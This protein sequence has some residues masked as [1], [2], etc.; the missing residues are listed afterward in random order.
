MSLPRVQIVVIR[1]SEFIHSGTFLELAET[2]YEGLQSLGASVGMAENHFDSE[3][4]NIVLGW[5]LLEPKQEK[6]LPA[7]CILYNLEQ[8][9]NENLSMLKRLIQ[10]SEK[11]E[12]WDYSLRNINIL[13]E[14]GFP[15]SIHHV[16]IGTMP[17]LSRIPKLEVQD[18][19]VLFY[20]SGNP[21]RAK[22]LEDL[23]KTGL[24]VH[25]VFG[26][27]G[28][29]R[30]AL[31]ARSKVV[32]NLH[33]YETKIFEM[34]RVSYLW[35]NKKAVVSEL[36]PDTE[37]DPELEGAARFVPY[38]QIVTACQ[39]LVADH[40]ARK[41]LE[42]RAYETMSRREETQIL[43]QVLAGEMEI[44]CPPRVSSD[45]DLD[46]P[47][48]SII[49]PV[50]NK[51]DYTRQCI[52]KLYEGTPGNLF[53]LIVVDNASTDETP[54][55]LASLGERVKVITSAE[56]V[57]FVGACNLGAAK[58]K[59]KHLVFLN[60]DTVPLPGWLEALVK[61]VEND[62]L[63]GA[64]GSQLI[65]PDGR[66]QEAGGLIFQ[67]GSGWNF[68]RFMDP[69]DPA[70]GNPIEVDYCSGASLLVRRDVFER[71]GGFDTRYAPAYYEDTDLCFGVRSLGLKVMYCPAS[72]V[73]HFEGITAGTDLTAGFKRFQEINREKFVAKWAEMLALQDPPPARS[74]RTPTT[75]DRKRLVSLRKPSVQAALSTNS[76][77]IHILI[78]DPFMP[79]HDR[80]SGSLRLFRI[81]LL[82]R[83]LGCDV[84]YIARNG[85]GQEAYKKQ[86]ENVGV[87]VFSTDPEKMAQL[88]HRVNAQRIDLPRILAEH[89]CHIA[90][91]SFYDIAEQYLCDIRKV[92]P[93]TTIMVD[94]V[95]VHFLRETR[96][97]QLAKDAGAMKRAA[98]TRE[99]ELRVY[100]QA[101]LVVTVTEADAEVLREAGLTAATLVI[102]NIH[103]E[104]EITP[105]WDTRQGLVFVGNFNHTPNIDAAQW[106]CRKIMP[107]IRRLL[108]GVKLNI[109]GPNPPKEVLALA[110]S[111]IKVL[112]WVPETAPYLD[113][114]RVSVA[115]IRVGA[116]M[117]GKIGEALSRSL[118]VVTTTIGAEGMDLVSGVDAMVADHPEAFADAVASI[119]NNRGAWE[120][121]AL[122]GR[123][124]VQSRYGVK[125]VGNMLK[126]MLSRYITGPETVVGQTGGTANPDKLARLIAFHLPQFHPI[127]E[128]DHWWGRGFTE[129]TNV[130][131]AQPLFL[132][133][134]Q[135]Q[136]PGELGFYDLRLEE[137]R[138]A[139]AQLAREHGIEG[140]CFWHYWFDGKLLLERPLL[141]SLHAGTPDFPYCLAWANENWT[142]RW[143]GQET[144]VL[145]PQTYG[146]DS[147]DAAHFEW[148]L[149][150]MK[151]KRAITVNG[152]PIFLIYRPGDLPD[153][154]RT[155]SLWRSMASTAGLPGLYLIAIVTSFR[156]Q[157][158]DWIREGF[159]GELLFQPNFDELITQATIDK[160]LQ[161]VPVTANGATIATYEHVWPRLAKLSEKNLTCPDMFASVVPGWDNTARRAQA[162]TILTN[163][164]SN[165]FGAWLRLEVERVQS[166]EPD[167]KIVF[168]NAWNE[169]AEG[170]HLEPDTRSG[171]EYLEAARWA[172]TEP[173][174]LQNSITPAG[175]VGPEPPSNK[176]TWRSVEDLRNEIQDSIDSGNLDHALGTLVGFVRDVITFQ[177]GESANGTE[178]VFGCAELDHICAGIGRKVLNRMSVDQQKIW[179]PR[180]VYVASGLYSTGGHSRVLDDWTNADKSREHVIL[181]TDLFPGIDRAQTEKMYPNARFEWAPAASL[182]A[183]LNWLISTLHSLMPER[184]F[185]FNHPEDSVAVS[186]ALPEL[187]KKVYFVHHADHS[188]S[189]G[190]F[191]QDVTHIDVSNICY[192]ICKTEH[193][194]KNLYVP[195]T[196]ID[197]GINRTPLRD[198][199]GAIVTCCSSSTFNKLQHHSYKYNYLDL[200]PWLFEQ[201][202]ARHIHIGPI[203]DPVLAQISKAMGERGIDPKRF[204][205]R[206]FEPVYWSALNALRVDVCIGSFPLGGGRTSVEA[207]GSGTPYIAHENYLQRNLGG[208]DLVYPTANVWQN[209]DQLGQ[210]LA[211]LRGED[212]RTQ[213]WGARHHFEQYHHHKRLEEALL[214]Q[215]GLI[216]GLEPLPLRS[217]QRDVMQATLDKLWLQAQT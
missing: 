181:M 201:G 134:H 79:I 13:H 58:A 202:I 62:P 49:V 91:L 60:N 146:G 2:I 217:F 140:F 175:N 10:L 194:I 64:A 179:K 200:F 108:P 57:G 156:N 4:V 46:L 142:R 17:A 113:A 165:D 173:F 16:P 117:K 197:F 154:R 34:V 136:L 105:G 159:D 111:D 126:A 137:A 55:F 118:P 94:T 23:L 85:I 149:P 92:S 81:I 208:Q 7:Q 38:E 153:P 121:M 70:F 212:R 97:A 147:D 86:L 203:P 3:A 48:S 32:L 135:P 103:E 215:Q 211:L 59:G 180:S 52:E 209:M 15:G 106:L 163:S 56:N 28:E 76:N 87:K 41:A 139:Q 143:D 213:A 157:A 102:P 172:V 66:L 31:I 214:D 77:A 205:H 124:S 122:A 128:N 199:N 100:G 36:S 207:M 125:A 132:G 177:Q 110:G 190:P 47:L 152:K 107:R 82:F 178:C 95:D 20:G 176:T 109:I 116:G 73:I 68:G 171:R 166:R 182:H 43:R 193:G 27:Y 129:W 133:H 71:L 130:A 21:R 54:G 195:I 83:A 26:V 104:A 53:E 196:S 51:A 30:D 40:R 6:G 206:P 39:L 78:V 119:Y 19:D 88:G 37:I 61:M 33:F 162:P 99:R 42:S 67:D 63:T 14:M 167:K 84:T 18:I 189:L 29:E 138:K 150:F 131:K 25:W 89:P 169:W 161:R 69:L 151:D 186:A 168:I 123:E 45:S 96:Q 44:S 90:W 216:A 22:I 114:A 183:K 184:I 155:L 191:L 192:H 101:D 24:Q 170:N 185:L 50:F 9:S 198:T 204:V 115:P 74:G 65:Y 210:A 144:Q 160:G 8:M 148:L 12:I 187:G 93:S 75:A 1:P 80:A 164:N 11:C 127:P 5:H 141:D 72:M 174:P 145:Q 158:K 188:F 35:A 98:A 120:A 112:G